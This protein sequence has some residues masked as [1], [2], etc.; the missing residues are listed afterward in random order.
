M[1]MR[2]LYSAHIEAKTTQVSFPGLA[3]SRVAAKAAKVAAQP[4]AKKRWLGWL[5]TGEMGTMV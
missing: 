2:R 3:S 5:L 1:L 4:P